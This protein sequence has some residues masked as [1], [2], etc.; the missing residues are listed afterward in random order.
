[1]DINLIISG[2]GLKKE[3]R[4]CLSGCET[5]DDLFHRIDQL[6]FE[7]EKEIDDEKKKQ[8]KQQFFT[9]DVEN[10]I[11][12]NAKLCVSAL[13]RHLYNKDVP[14]NVDISREEWERAWLALFKHRHFAYGF[15]RLFEELPAETIWEEGLQGDFLEKLNEIKANIAYEKQLYLSMAGY[16]AVFFGRFY[17]NELAIIMLCKYYPNLSFDEDEKEQI[18]SGLFSHIIFAG[19]RHDWGFAFNGINFITQWIGSLDKEIVLSLL[20]KYK[21]SQITGRDVYRHQI[22]AIITNS[23]LDSEEQTRYKF[24]YLD[25]IM[26]LNRIQPVIYNRL[27]DGY[28]YVVRKGDI[29]YL[30]CA[31]EEYPFLEREGGGEEYAWWIYDDTTSLYHIKEQILIEKRPL[32]L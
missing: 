16:F 31:E 18:V 20:K 3:D 32:N 14:S 2:L 12:A 11:K 29:D 21:V 26:I 19:G 15:Y 27:Y 22:N 25:S 7:W 17:D 4:E 6:F 24:L 1:M 8:E 28:K 5:I 10:E 30:S 23:K 13:I 9:D